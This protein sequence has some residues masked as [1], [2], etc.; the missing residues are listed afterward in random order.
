MTRTE[1]L[2][3]RLTDE[4]KHLFDGALQ[5]RNVQ[6]IAQDI[7]VADLSHEIRNYYQAKGT[8][9]SSPDAIHLATAILY[10]ANEFHTFD[11]GGI[12][13]SLGLLP[14][15]G[16]VGGHRLTICKPQA[17]NPGLDLRKPVH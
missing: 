11:N 14:L 17:R 13:K 5:R 9:L 7:R 3:C 15:S 8:K 16:N 6:L 2:E 12:G 1:V 10:R 4:A